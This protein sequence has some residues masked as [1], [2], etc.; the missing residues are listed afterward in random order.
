M[1]QLYRG[2]PVAGFTVLHSSPEFGQPVVSFPG[3]YF[4]NEP[5]EIRSANFLL[6][7]MFFFSPSLALVQP[8][9]QEA[10]AEGLT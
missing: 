1:K 5:E 6:L 10:A 8:L 3:L 2:G 7:G 4:S 9:F